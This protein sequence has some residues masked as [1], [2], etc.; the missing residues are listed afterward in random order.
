MWLAA[1]SLRPSHPWLSGHAGLA[2]SDRARIHANLWSFRI[3]FPKEL[4]W[5]SSVSH[6]SVFSKVMILRPFQ[7]SVGWNKPRAWKS[8]QRGRFGS[9]QIHSRR[10]G[11]IL[12]CPRRGPWKSSHRRIHW[13]PLVLV[14]LIARLWRLIGAP[15]TGALP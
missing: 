5:V 2:P 10:G 7:K 1:S 3:Q 4:L 11:N 14:G 12:C 15:L 9:G 8:S 13:P 6:S